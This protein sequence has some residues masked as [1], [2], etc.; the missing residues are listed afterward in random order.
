MTIDEI[1]KR[2]DLIDEQLVAL[3]NTRATCALE[4]ER[5]KRAAGLPL[6]QPAREDE[7]GRHVRAVTDQMGGPLTGKAVGRLFER[8][9]D[10]ARQL[11]RGSASDPQSESAGRR[12][13]GRA[14][15][16]SRQR[17]K[18]NCSGAL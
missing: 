18:P 6:Y 17:R 9:I 15:H 2:I 10:E 13:G 3:L 7:V 4:I 5:L 11:E 16:K 8:I 1:R 12:T 14:S